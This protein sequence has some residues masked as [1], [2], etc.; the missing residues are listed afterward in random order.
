MLDIHPVTP[1]RWDDL[2]RLFGPSGAYSGCW[3]MWWRV[4]SSEFERESG[5]GLKAAM[6]TL[7]AAGPPPGLLAY[8][9]G[10]PIGWVSLGNRDDFGRLN[11][12]PKLKSVDD[13]Q[14]CSVVCFFID[15][16]HRRTGVAAELLEAAVDQARTDGHALIEGYPI[17]TSNSKPGTADLFTGTLALFEQAGFREV[18]RRGGRPIVRRDL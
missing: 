15:R 4:T 13:R 18:L 10:E 1:H 11:R 7:V 3:C 8:L 9:A 5:D 14:V 17:D 2:Q 16:D 12:S 6:Q